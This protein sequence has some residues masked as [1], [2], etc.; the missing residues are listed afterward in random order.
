MESSAVCGSQ[1]TS[2]AQRCRGRTD[3][4]VSGYRPGGNC[5][6]I[7]Y[8]AKGTKV[9][10]ARYSH[11]VSWR[12][13]GNRRKLWNAEGFHWKPEVALDSLKSC[14]FVCCLQKEAHVW[15][16]VHGVPVQPGSCLVV[17]TETVPRLIINLI[18][19][20]LIQRWWLMSSVLL[21]RVDGC[22]GCHPLIGNRFVTH[23]TRCL[24][25][26]EKQWSI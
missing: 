12:E 21:F 26:A 20:L 2:G 11:S 8:V 18:I 1:R 9:S 16:S 14:L 17:S 5:Y 22:H 23:F 10:T 15:S 13:L 3:V 19:N 7:I 24:R 4:L 25:V 6:N